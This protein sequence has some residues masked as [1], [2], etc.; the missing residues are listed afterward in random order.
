ML[1]LAEQLQPLV[2]IVSILLFLLTLELTLLY[3]LVEKM[4]II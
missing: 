3:L 2:D 4:L 1:A